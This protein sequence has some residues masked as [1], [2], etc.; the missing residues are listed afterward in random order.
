MHIVSYSIMDHDQLNTHVIRING[1]FVEPRDACINIFDH[2]FLFGDSIYEVVQTVAGKPYAW[3]AHMARLRNSAKRLSYDLPWSEDELLN[4]VKAAVDAKKWQG[5]SYVR[6]IITRGVGEINLMPTTCDNPSLIIIA[7]ELPLP[8]PKTDSGVVLCVTDVRRNSRKAMD[9][10]IKSG[11]Y[12]NNVLAMIEAKGKGADDALMLNENN[13]LTEI[14]T[15]NFFLVSNGIVRTPSLECGILDGITRR[16]I[17]EVAKS[18][19][20]EVVETELSIDDLVSAD[21][22][23]ITGTIK[24]VVPVRKIIG[25]AAWEGEPGPIA[26]RIRRAYKNISGVV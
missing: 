18:E 13:H 3:D 15:S 14:T 8:G 7:K 4:E 11:N 25:D 10:G 24:G 6:L 21:E 19:G 5:E 20:I 22:I 16:K 26:G 17:I 12:L 9:P 1:E 23:F 2:A